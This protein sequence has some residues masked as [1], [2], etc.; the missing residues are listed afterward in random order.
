MV[1]ASNCSRVQVLS[2]ACFSG[3]VISRTASKPT[4]LFSACTAVLVTSG[5]TTTLR[6]RGSANSVSMTVVITA[7][8]KPCTGFS[9][10]ATRKC[11]PTSPGS[12]SYSPL[13][14]TSVGS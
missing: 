14:S 3:L 1:A 7:R 9:G 4:A 5:S 12:A 2:R 13:S 6:T 10:G 8:V 11:I